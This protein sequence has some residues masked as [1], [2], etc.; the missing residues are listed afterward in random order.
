MG[1]VGE[2]EC[3]SGGMIA[4]A[5]FKPLDL[6]TEVALNQIRA[7]K[8]WTMVFDAI[9]YFGK[10]DTR[11]DCPKTSF[12]P[13]DDF[14]TIALMA[15]TASMTSDWACLLNSDIVVSPM[16]PGVWRQ[17]VQ[18]GAKAITSY[19]W[20][21]SQDDFELMNA[22]VVDNGF[23]FFC[24]TPDLW[25]RVSQ[26]VPASYRIGHNAFDSWLLG[27]F[28]S[29]LKRK[30][31]DITAKRCVFHPKHGDRQQKWP[32]AP[33]GTKYDYLAGAPSTRMI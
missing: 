29:V 27:F 15:L 25:R 11:L 7:K 30:F 22:K 5:S 23:D 4:V 28:N 31:F 32:V 21:Y 1:R 12:I 2:A 8:S 20:E 6:S 13:Y 16:L 24:A 14:P 9:I 3:R 10:R 19:R 17:A 26:E 33:E 18:Q